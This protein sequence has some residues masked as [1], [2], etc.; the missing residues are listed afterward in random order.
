MTHLGANRVPIPIPM[1]FT[2]IRKTMEW[3]S[4]VL[5]IVTVSFLWPLGVPV[6]V[7]IH[8][9]FVGMPMYKMERKASV[10]LKMSHY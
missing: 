5:P 4:F 3:F 8:S 10:S 1:S 7:C 9:A 2:T 6:V